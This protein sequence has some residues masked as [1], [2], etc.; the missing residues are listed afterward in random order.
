MFK[1][2]ES[3]EADV[4]EVATTVRA[5]AK[6]APNKA[7]RAALADVLTTRAAM[8][9]DTALDGTLKRK[10]SSASS[11]KPKK[12]VS[13]KDQMQK[14]FD[15]DMAKI[16]ALQTACT[17]CILDAFDQDARLSDLCIFIT[18][19]IEQLGQK[20]RQTAHKMT[21]SGL[22]HQEAWRPVDY[23]PQC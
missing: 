21:A 5:T 3:V 10:G 15:K 8:S 11:T 22:Q 6:I 7:A 9:S 16:L 19:R 14:D 23:N 12:A 17:L 2:K 4:S 20:A 18:P 13:A 1:E